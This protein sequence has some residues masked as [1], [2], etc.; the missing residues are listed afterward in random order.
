MAL[1]KCAECNNE[2]SDQASFCPKCGAPVA[3][4]APIKKVEEIRD[5]IDCP[6]CGEH[7]NASAETCGHC[8]AEYGYHNSSNNT[9]YN[10]LEFDR[11]YKRSTHH[12]VVT[13]LLLAI[14]VVITVSLGRSGVAA[15]TGIAV[16]FV[17]PF[18]VLSIFAVINV[19]SMKSNGK[20]WWKSR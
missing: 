10:D 6:F 3:G 15:L 9:T 5:G 19:R 12:F 20:K 2:V 4:S 7:I 17:A 14:L 18:V 11:L 13:G 8:G 16:L 1:I